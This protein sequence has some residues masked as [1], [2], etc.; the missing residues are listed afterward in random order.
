MHTTDTPETPETPETPAPAPAS[1]PAK[2]P[3]ITRAPDEPRDDLYLPPGHSTTVAARRAHLREFFPKAST[4]DAK[5]I[6]LVP[7]D[8]RPQR[9]HVPRGKVRS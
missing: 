6:C 2:L 5:R 9:V 7:P 8:Q 3:K 4:R 1:A